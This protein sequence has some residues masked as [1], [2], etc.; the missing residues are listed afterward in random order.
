[1]EAF[2]VNLWQNA[3]KQPWIPTPPYLNSLLSGKWLNELDPDSS[4]FNQVFTQWAM[5]LQTYFD[6]YSLLKAVLEPVTF[7]S[8]KS[9]YNDRETFKQNKLIINTPVTLDMLN[10]WD[11]FVHPI[12]QAQIFF[13]KPTNNRFVTWP[14]RL[15]RQAPPEI[16]NLSSTLL[17]NIQGN[18]S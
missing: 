7:L 13:F 3:I 11:N 6:W 4:Y 14:S 17:F 5:Q 12:L 16:C 18:F 2:T 15:L 1:M 10:G 8:W 9:A